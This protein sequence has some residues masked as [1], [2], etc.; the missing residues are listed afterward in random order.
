[1]IDLKKIKRLREEKGL[2]IEE[3]SK[4]LGFKTYQGYYKLERGIRRIRV[5]HLIKLSKI[6]NVDIKD[7]ILEEKDEHN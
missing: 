4:H 1:M 6:L 7:L 3:I 5:D 2:S